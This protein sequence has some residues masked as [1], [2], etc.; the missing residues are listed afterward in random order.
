MNEAA[1]LS[2][3]GFGARAGKLVYGQAKCT[4]GIRRGT[5]KMLIL[6][7]SV[8]QGTLKSFTDAC[9]THNVPWLLLRGHDVLGPSVGRPE[10]RLVGIKDPD[11]ARSMSE[12]YGIESGRGAD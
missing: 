12:K 1:A 2:F 5:I 9:R 10:C 3:L 7:G 6:D 11:F 8:S 4:A